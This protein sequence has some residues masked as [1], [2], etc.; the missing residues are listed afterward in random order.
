MKKLNLTIVLVLSFSISVLAG[1]NYKTLFFKS[2]DGVEISLKVFAEEEVDEPMYFDTQEVSAIST[3]VEKVSLSRE[4][5]DLTGISIPEQ[6]FEETINT[7]AIFQQLK[8]QSEMSLA[9]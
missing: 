6:D 8:G 4:P 2:L 1:G 5:I 9:K 7:K 3:K